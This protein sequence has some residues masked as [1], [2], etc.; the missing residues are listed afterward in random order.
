MYQFLI[1]STLEGSVATPAPE[2]IWPRYSTCDM[3]NT[4]L[5]LLAVRQCCLSNCKTDL[6]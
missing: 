2:I 5:A 4:H 3:A 1:A 6:K